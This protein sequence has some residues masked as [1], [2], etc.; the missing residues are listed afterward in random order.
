MSTVSLLT[1]ELLRPMCGNP[2]TATQFTPSR[3]AMTQRDCDGVF[4][5]NE[6]EMH[7]R[8]ARVP[9][10]SCD[11]ADR[12]CN[13]G[14]LRF[15]DAETPVHCQHAFQKCSLVHKLMNV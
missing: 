4:Q 12:K 6:S 9:C 2:L 11:K 5:C 15:R 10:E 14:A 8:H 1:A 13:A 3:D 7:L